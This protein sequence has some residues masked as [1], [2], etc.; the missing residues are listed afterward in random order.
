MTEGT[1]SIKDIRRAVKVLKRNDH[2]WWRLW[3][4]LRHRPK[5][6]GLIDMND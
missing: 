5:Y 3:Y 1:I 6:V 4:K 2:W